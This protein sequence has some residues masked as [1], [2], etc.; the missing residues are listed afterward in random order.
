MKENR[1]RT[2]KLEKCTFSFRFQFTYFSE[3]YK[4]IFVNNCIDHK[5]SIKPS[6]ARV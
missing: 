2:K 4:F 5:A 1:E 3:L 6:F